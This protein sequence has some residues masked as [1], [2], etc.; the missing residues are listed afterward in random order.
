METLVD[1]THPFDH[2]GVV[3]HG[4]EVGEVGGRALVEGWAGE[5]GEEGKEEGWIRG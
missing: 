3:E 4:E 5:R 2:M 1:L